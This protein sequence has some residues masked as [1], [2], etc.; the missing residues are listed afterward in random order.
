MAREIA[1]ARDMGIVNVNVSSS[2]DLIPQK[3]R[4]QPR[5]RVIRG[6]ILWLLKIHHYFNG[7]E[8]CSH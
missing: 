1:D 3:G 4:P 2:P 8:W 5:R 6:G 7:M